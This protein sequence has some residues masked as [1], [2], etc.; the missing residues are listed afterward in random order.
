MPPPPHSFQLALLFTTLACSKIS[1]SWGAG[2]PTIYRHR[3][4]SGEGICKTGVESR[5]DGDD[6]RGP[7]Q[8]MES[9]SAL[10][11]SYLQHGRAVTCRQ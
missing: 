5:L 9:G 6:P 11:R 2:R 10:G 3:E 4:R 1:S 7:N 8:V